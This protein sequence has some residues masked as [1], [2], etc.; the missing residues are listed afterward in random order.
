MAAE[1]GEEAFGPTET[2][3]DD[4]EDIVDALK[5]K[6]GDV[7]DEDPSDEDPSDGDGGEEDGDGASDFY[8]D[9][10]HEDGESFD[11]NNYLR[12]KK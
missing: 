3:P 2:L 11:P 6:F 10:E 1:K 7:S 4:E 8:E 12:F 5:K 9:E